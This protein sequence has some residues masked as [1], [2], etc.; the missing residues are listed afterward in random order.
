MK[1]KILGLLYTALIGSILTGCATIPRLTRIDDVSSQEAIVAT[2]VRLVYN[3]EDM[4]VFNV[5]FRPV[6]ATY[7]QKYLYQNV[8]NES[9]YI[10]TKVPAGKNCIGVVIHKSGLMRHNFDPDD[11]TFQARGGGVINY[12]GDITFTWRGMSTG[13]GLAT[14]AASGLLSSYA[15]GGDIQ[16][17]V[18]SNVA[19]A[20]AAFKQKYPTDRN[21]TPSLLI[22][23]APH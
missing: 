16:V 7:S 15:T 3:G 11:L 9:G 8:P 5:I 17:S 14:A 20:Q 13:A 4:P 21:I 18:Q 12:I 2:K 10:F 22:V 19:S 6:P 23:R 1:T